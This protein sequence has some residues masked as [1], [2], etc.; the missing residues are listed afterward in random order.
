MESPMSFL[1]LGNVQMVL[2]RWWLHHGGSIPCDHVVS[3]MGSQIEHKD[4]LHANI[5]AQNT[6]LCTGMKDVS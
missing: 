3:T 5:Q 4:V 2:I 6:A 1:S